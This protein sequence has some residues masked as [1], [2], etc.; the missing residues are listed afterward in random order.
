MQALSDALH[1]LNSRGAWCRHV[2][3]PAAPSLHLLLQ[4][5]CSPPI[6]CCLLLPRWLLQELS[7]ALHL[8]DAKAADEAAAAAG[9]RRRLEGVVKSLEGRLAQASG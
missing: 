2:Q 8:L 3:S 6:C 1:L 7:D 4:G 5:C 9:D